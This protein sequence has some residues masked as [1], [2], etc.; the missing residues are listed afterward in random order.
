HMQTREMNTRE[1]IA[2]HN[3]GVLDIGLM[4]NTPL[5]D[6]LKREVILH[7]PLIAM[8][9]R[10]HRLAQKPDVSLTELSE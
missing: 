7:E 6:T 1:Q 3:E 5:P 4:R 10:E 8:I 2:P 9:P